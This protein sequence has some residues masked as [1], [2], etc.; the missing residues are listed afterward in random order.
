MFDSNYQSIGDCGVTGRF[1]RKQSH[2]SLPEGFRFYLQED[3]PMNREKNA[4]YGRKGY[5]QTHPCKDTFVCQHCG[6]TVLPDGA[7]TAHRNHCPKCLFSL[8]L[9]MEPG[10]REAGCGGSM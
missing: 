3:A 6:K 8:H 4:K 7:G 10:D 2:T 9:D 5:Y 1:A